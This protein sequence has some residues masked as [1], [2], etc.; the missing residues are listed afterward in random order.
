MRS[1]YFRSRPVGQEPATMLT[2][3]HLMLTRQHRSGCMIA[4]ANGN[5]RNESG[6]GKETSVLPPA[7]RGL[8]DAGPEDASRTSARPKQHVI[9]ATRAPAETLS[10]SAPSAMSARTINLS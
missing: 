3:R 8:A 1:D 10:G 4:S 2:A 9:L 6:S 5:R 7:A